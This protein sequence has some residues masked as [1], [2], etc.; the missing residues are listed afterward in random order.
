MIGALGNVNFLV[1]D[2]KIRTFDDFRRSS[3]GRWEDHEVLGKKPLSQWIGPGLDSISFKM[4]FD[5][6]YG[7]NPRVE[8]DRLVKMERSGKPYTLTIGDKAFGVYKWTI[9]QLDED[10]ITVDNKGRLLVS[11]VTIELKEYVK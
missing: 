4:R 10:F 2:K 6:A 1:T 3:A 8:M 5:V 7:L 9:R 11:E